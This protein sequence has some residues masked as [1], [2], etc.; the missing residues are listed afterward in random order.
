MKSEKAL[1]LLSC[2]LVAGVLSH[3]GSTVAGANIVLFD[4]YIQPGYVHDPFGGYATGANWGWIAFAFTPSVDAR[5]ESVTLSLG[6]KTS[7]ADVIDVKLYE[8]AGGVPGADLE[9]FHLINAIPPLYPE[10]PVVVDSVFHPILRDG[11]QYWLSVQGSLQTDAGWYRSARP[12]LG[13]RARSHPLAFPDWIIDEAPMAVF[14]VEG[15]PPVPEPG[16]LA[17]VGGGLLVLM[18]RRRQG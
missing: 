6:F 9:S 14:R 18:R 17:L 5:L 16:T 10:P 7:A 15:S 4:N 3:A 1:R 11:H 12:D 2:V 13:T 8:D